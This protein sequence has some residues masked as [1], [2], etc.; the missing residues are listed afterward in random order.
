MKYI[1]PIFLF[2]TG[3]IVNAQQ[4][5]DCSDAIVVCGNSTIASNATGFGRQELDNTANA[6]FYEEL[7]SLW[8]SVNIAT[9]GDLAFTIRPDDTNL[10]VDYDF[11][12]FGPN[13]GCGNFN[14][15]IRCNTTN[16]LQAGL[17]NNTTGLRD[18]EIET[19]GGPGVDGNGFVSSIP[20]TTGEQYYILVD[21]PIGNGGFSLEWTG[22]AG[23][24]PSPEVNEPEDIEFCVDETNLLVDLT[25][26]E[27]AITT[28]T[29]AVISYYT[30]YEDAFDSQNAIPDATQFSYE[31]IFTPIFVR[32]NNP[33]GCFEIVTFTLS[34]LEFDSPPD[35]SYTLCDSDRN[36]REPFSIPLILEDIENSMRDISEFTI[37]LHPTEVDA[38]ADSRRL[39]GAVF[40]TATNQ[41][42][43]RVSS[44]RIVDCTIT[45]PVQLIMLPDPFP[46]IVNLVQ[47]DVDEDN[48]LDG[49]TRINLEQS[50]PELTDAQVFYYETIADRDAD[51]P[52]VNPQDYTN[53]TAF[54]ET[55][56]YRIV[57][58]ICE[59]RGEIAIAVNATLVSSNPVSPI[60]QCDDDATD[61]LLLST[62]NITEIRETNYSGL[63]VAIYGNLTDVSLEQNPL[64]GNLRTTSTTIYVRLENGNQCQAVEEIQ[65]VVNPL[66][67]FNLEETY[68]VCTDGE[69]LMI[70][71]PDGFDSYTWYRTD[72]QSFEQIGTNQI[73]SINS[74]GN[75]QL[76]IGSFYESNGQT[77]TCTSTDDF[78][79]MPSNRAVIQQVMIEDV[80]ENNSFEVLVSGDGDYEFSIDNENYQ[81]EPKFE[82]LDPGFYTI[83][84][85][86]R[87]GCGTTEKEISLIGFPKFFTP[88]GDGANDT[89]QIIGANT[90]FEQRVINI[91]DRYGKLVKQ[92]ST[93]DR[94]WDG[95]MNGSLLPSSDYWFQ[96]T[97][98]NGKEFKGHFT[99]KR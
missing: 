94:G 47:C 89:W 90:S 77:V 29:I 79:V 10:E 70:I 44:N 1:L 35:L 14:D 56:Y 13:N 92:I 32:V 40:E 2:F 45:Y 19:S 48:S 55:V 9:D 82:R 93:N 74:A 96:I 72:A 8:L 84:V 68:Q 64:D 5:N 95:S 30:S 57:S 23:F 34:P 52:I 39:T 27:A 51:N 43:A 11:Y 61:N 31:G 91:F 81:D 26:Q 87:K 66:P 86:D 98:E 60:L 49:I 36:G 12:V 16:P 17:S 22:T 7:N 24:L 6:C 97:L 4:A 62:F 65:L 41:I 69:P 25:N 67:D 18:T 37:S 33:N 63:D 80:T 3:L 20:V 99:L 46:Q 58:D 15:P 21:R 28:S 85:R 53:R 42:Y 50:F 38:N 88:N 75:Y 54:N 59:S 78:V 76:E 73:V 83:Y 71:A